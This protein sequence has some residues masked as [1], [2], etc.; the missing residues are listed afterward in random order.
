M[1]KTKY[2]VTLLDSKWNAVKTNVKLTFLPRRDEYVFFDG[3]YYLVL[4]VVHTLDGQQGV[5]IIID[6]TT[7]QIKKV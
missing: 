3:L 4:N 1:F 2:K 5:F 6:E 7:H